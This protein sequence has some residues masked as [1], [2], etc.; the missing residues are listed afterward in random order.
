MFY[1]YPLPVDAGKDV[2]ALVTLTSAESKRLIAR[3]VAAMPEVKKAQETGI[4]IIARGT[5]NT[6]VAEE[7]MGTSIEQKGE[8]SRGIITGGELNVNRRRGVG[9]D[10][11]LKD[12][13]LWDISPREVFP[14]FGR[15]DVFFK[16]ASA[17]DA[18]GEAAVLVAGADA[19]TIGAAL[20]SMIARS[21][22]LIVPVG[23]E[24][25]VPSVADAIR[26]CGVFNYKYSIGYPCALIP[27]VNA[28]V[29][30]EIQALGIL[31]GVRA[32]HVASGG[33]GGS[34]GAV[35]L[36][37]EG[38]EENMERAISLLKTIKGEPPVPSPEIM[39]PP[40]AGL[41]YDAKAIQDANRH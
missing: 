32:T 3:G 14:Q 41:N 13:K 28:K 5:T 23:L 8:Y 10:F 2:S 17:V 30:T 12:G 6:F 27:L 1:Q 18:A 34:E 35:V 24:K 4:I 22:N 21:A 16:G 38:T 37:V 39:G 9:N 25:L 19:G 36:V 15:D 40:S 11:V 31:S 33:I 29:V 26:K 20:P 7:V